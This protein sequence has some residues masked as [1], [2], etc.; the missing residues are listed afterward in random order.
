MRVSP[1]S[2]RQIRI[3]GLAAISAGRSDKDHLS[4]E[5]IVSAEQSFIINTSQSLS[6]P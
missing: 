4:L 2:L 1:N 6:P 3:E 5:R